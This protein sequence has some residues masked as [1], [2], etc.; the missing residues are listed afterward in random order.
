MKKIV[1]IASL[2][3]SLNG[4]AQNAEGKIYFPKG[5][6]LEVTTE[7]KKTATMEL[8]GLDMVSTVNSTLT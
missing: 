1:C 5:Q 6:K 3:L 7:T 8:M 4:L 2:A